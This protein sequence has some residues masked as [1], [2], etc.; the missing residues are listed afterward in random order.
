[1]GDSLVKIPHRA[2]QELYIVKLLY[3]NDNGGSI[4]T[5][6]GIVESIDKGLE[7][8]QDPCVTQ[9]HGFKRTCLGLY[10]PNKEYIKRNYGIKVGIGYSI[11][12]E[13]SYILK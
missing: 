5:V 12:F 3:H 11:Q 7:I 8:F 13:L 6:L 4:H 1:M 9:K 2:T 10:M